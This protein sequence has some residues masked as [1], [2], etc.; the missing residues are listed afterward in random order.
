MRRWA[1]RSIARRGEFSE[2]AAWRSRREGPEIADAEAVHHNCRRIGADRVERR[3]SEG[4]LTAKARQQI[5]AD[6]GDGVNQH[7]RDL[8]DEERGKDKGQDDEDCD[9]PESD[10]ELL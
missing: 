4:K 7:H 2:F 1:Y 8:E 5:Q 3:V 6:D 9:S 10:R